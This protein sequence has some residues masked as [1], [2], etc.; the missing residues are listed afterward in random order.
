LTSLR[1]KAVSSVKWTTLQTIVSGIQGP[2]LLL[3]KSRFLSPDDFAHIAIIMIFV[4]LFRLLESFGIN[5]AIIQRDNISPTESKSL[6]FFN[7]ILSLLLALVLFLSSSAIAGFFSLPDLDNYLKV[8]TVVVILSGPS[9]IFRAFLQKEL[10]FKQLSLIEI[11][12]SL[13]VFVTT[14]SFLLMGLGVLSIIYSQIIGVSIATTAVIFVAARKGLINFRTV[15][16]PKAVFPF[17]RFGVFV[18][19]KQLMTFFAHRLDEIVIGYFLSSEVLGIYHFGKNMLEKLRGLITKSFAKVLFP[20]FS[21]FKHNQKKLSQ[22]Y[23][24][25]SKYIAFGSFPVFLGILVTAP[26]FVPVLFGDQWMDS[27]IVFQVFSVVMIFLVLTAN[28]S[29]S[30]IY[31]VNKPDL[32]FYIDIITNAIYFILLFVFAK[33]GINAILLTYS[34]YV[35]LKTLFLQYYANKQLEDNFRHYFYNLT[36]PGVISGVMAIAIYTLQTIL[37]IYFS[38]LTLLVVSIIFG[39]TVY[40]LLTL[41]FARNTVDE[42]LN[43]FKETKT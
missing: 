39:G 9:G 7:L 12:S 34:C 10:Y 43:F 23:Q 40:V 17:L 6:L 5:Q 38:N 24:K 13:V 28:V 31:S 36:A 14:I 3:I 21:K 2:L 32:V 20:V 29:S 18:S 15:Y 35:I 26:L 41:S 22:A 8:I 11:L 16:K 27:I 30:L 19:A 42:F 4:G 33:N 25:I 37:D 1:N